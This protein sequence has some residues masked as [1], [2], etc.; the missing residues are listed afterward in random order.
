MKK[1]LIA[2]VASVAFA[3][4]LSA[5]AQATTAPAAAPVVQA[6]HASVETDTAKA[7]HTKVIFIR[8]S[9]CTW[10][11]KSSHNG[12]H[13]RKIQGS[14]EGHSWIYVQTTTGWKSGWRHGRFSAGVSMY[15]RKGMGK[16][17]YSWHKT[18]RNETA[19]LIRH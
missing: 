5:S 6:P 8:R 12:A 2:A 1:L 3:P 7:A 10:I 18:R 16:V 15:E 13:T 11:A 9:G 19:R 17:K 4:V 14:C